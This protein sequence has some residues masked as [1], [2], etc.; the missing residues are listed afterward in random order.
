MKYTIQFYI[1]MINKINKYMC[2]TADIQNIPQNTMLVRIGVS[3][4]VNVVGF[5]LTPIVS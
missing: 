5:A 1:D 3:E 2:I 4:S